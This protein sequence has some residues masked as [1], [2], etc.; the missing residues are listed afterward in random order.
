VQRAVRQQFGRWGLPACLR[1]DN[2]VP[3]GNWNDLPT[4]FALWVVGLGVRWHWN[5]PH[6]PQQNPKVERSQGTGKRWAEPGTCRTAAELQA[7]LDEADRLQREVYVTA[8]GASRLELFPALRHSGRA[9]T[10][11][12]EKRAWSLSLVEDHLAEY[13]GV[14]RVSSGGHVAIYDRLRYVGRQYTGQCVHVQYD[15]QA[16]GWLISDAHGREL[17]RHEAPEISRDRIVKLTFRKTGQRP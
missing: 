9:Y 5:D 10:A 2:G 16:H 13:V 8:A 14:R 11:A 4:P 3:W 1:V 12:W 17:R 6:C 7:R 15:P